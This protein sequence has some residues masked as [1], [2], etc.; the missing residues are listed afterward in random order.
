[1]TYQCRACSYRS[2]RFPGGVC[3]GCG[4]PDVGR[5]GSGPASRPRARKPYLL[6]LCIALW[7]YLILAIYRQLAP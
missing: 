1:M 6:L 2:S 3:P 7:F 5:I 4:S